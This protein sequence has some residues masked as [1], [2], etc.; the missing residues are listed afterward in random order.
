MRPTKDEYFMEIAF[1]VSKRSV[2]IR[3]KV[4]AV[5][6]KDGHIIATG[7][8]GPPKGIEHCSES[9]CIRN[10]LNIPHGKRHELCFGLHAEQNAL[11]Q[12]AVHGTPCIGATIYITTHPCIVCTKILINA[13]IER[14]VYVGDYPDELSRQMLDESKIK[15]EK[16]SKK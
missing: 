12:S 9:T 14:I 7:Y 13:E 11:I 10:K 8:N 16:F 5:L 4:G 2:C 3:R 15:I 1:L 6:V